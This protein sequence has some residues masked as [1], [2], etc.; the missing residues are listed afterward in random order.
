TP[1]NTVH[2]ELGARMM[3]FAGWEMPVQYDSPLREHRAVRERVGVFDVSHMGQIEIV[4]KDALSVAQKLTSNDIS[5]LSDGQAQ[6]S[7]FLYPEGTFVD[8]IVL[9][10]INSEHIFI[11]VNA[12]NKDKDLQWA[13]RA[14]KGDV[15]FLDNSNSYVQLAIQGPEAQAVLQQLT[16]VDLSSMKYYWFAFGKVEGAKALISRTGYTGEDGFEIYIPPDKAESIWRKLFTVG[17]PFEIMPAG[18]AARNTLRLEMRYPLYGNDIDDHTTPWEAGLGWIVKLGKGDFIGKE[19]LEKQKEEGVQR[20]LVGF[21]M[22][23]RGIA[24]DHY[25][26]LIDG[27]QV[28]QVASGSFAPSLQKSIGLTYLPIECSQIGQLLD[29]EIRR[30]LL[31]AKVVETPFYKK[32]QR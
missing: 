13:R 21:E 16:D 12:A 2:R 10:R 30:K 1:L 29:V 11:C 5:R 18:L 31:K 6:Y 7:A 22:V 14:K 32:R 8:D 19:T 4:G 23:D 26:I 25:P 17:K 27:Q 20:K 24:R 9:Y 15:Q 28:S 3:G